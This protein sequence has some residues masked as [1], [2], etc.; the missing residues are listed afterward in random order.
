MLPVTLNCILSLNEVIWQEFLYML[1]LQSAHNSKTTWLFLQQQCNIWEVSSRGR[2]SSSH[3]TVGV[4]C[5]RRSVAF[6]NNA[7]EIKTQLIYH[8]P[9]NKVNVI[10]LTE[11][12]IRGIKYQLLK[13]PK[14]SE[15]L[16]DHFIFICCVYNIFLNKTVYVACPNVSRSW[17]YSERAEN[18]HWV[19]NVI[20]GSVWNSVNE[21]FSSV[22]L[23]LGM[24]L[25]AKC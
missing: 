8:W 3:L 16:D 17:N 25:R 9:S 14:K 10:I 19:T 1:L 18:C 23:Y 5:V 20:C 15:V 6:Y 4:Q 13:A 22:R 11:A 21:E 7:L 12:K 2:P 24:T